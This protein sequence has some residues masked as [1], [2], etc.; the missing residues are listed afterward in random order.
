MVWLDF[1]GG[2]KSKPASTTPQ[3][4]PF[5][6]FVDP[7][8]GGSPTPANTAAWAPTQVGAA[9]QPYNPVTPPPENTW[10]S[11]YQMWQDP[12]NGALWDPASGLWIDPATMNVY[13][14][15]VGWQSIPEY[16]DYSNVLWEHELYTPY[17]VVAQPSLFQDTGPKQISGADWY[18]IDAAMSR[19]RLSQAQ[20]EHE[21]YTPYPSVGEN[22]NTLSGT[23]SGGYTRNE[24]ASLPDA[25]AAR[26]AQA[27]TNFRQDW[28]RQEQQGLTLGGLLGSGL[29]AYNKYIAN[30]IAETGAQLTPAVLELAKYAPGLQSVAAIPGMLG[31]DSRTATQ[32]GVGELGTALKQSG[33]NPLTFAELQ[34]ENFKERPGWQQMASLAVFDPTN[35][36]GAGLTTKALQGV[37]GEGLLSE[38][39]RGAGA[40]NQA[41]DTATAKVVGGALKPL[42]PALKPLAAE[43]GSLPASLAAKAGLGAAVGGATYLAS[44]S[45]D[46]PTQRLLKSL[47]VGL[48][49]A[50]APDA[51]RAGYGKIPKRGKTAAQLSASL[52]TL[53][54][55]PL[56]NSGNV[57]ALERKEA[58]TAQ[59]GKLGSALGKLPGVKGVAGVVNPSI[60]LERSVHVANQ[61]EAAVRADLGTRFTATRKPLLQQVQDAFGQFVK[62]SDGYFRPA[63][64]PEYIGPP[65]RVI[66]GTIVDMMENP[67]DYALTPIQKST[68]DLWELRDAQNVNLLRTQHAADIGILR[69]EGG[70]KYVPHINTNEDLV[71]QGLTTEQRL[72]NPAL[73]KERS[74]ETA[75]QRMAADP[76]FKPETDPMMLMEL[77]DN[78]LARLGGQQTFKEGVGGYTRTELIEQV[79]PDLVQ[80]K[81]AAQSRLASL[82]GKLERRLQKETDLAGAVRKT[83][84]KQ[85]IV[86]ERLAP[87]EARV[88][89]LAETGDYGP[90]LSHL[91]GQVYELR[92]QADALE[93]VVKG[94]KKRPGMAA[95]LVTNDA[96]IRSI[97]TQ[98]EAA[99]KQVE[100]LVDA[101]AN[102]NLTRHGF[103]RSDYT[104][105]YHSPEVAESISEI[106]KVS[107][108]SWDRVTNIFDVARGTALSAD[109]SPIQVQGVMQTFRD[110]ISTMKAW[111]LMILEGGSSLDDVARRE[112]ELVSRYVQ[113]RARALGQVSDEF[114]PTQSLIASI[115]HGVGRKFTHVENAMFNA[116]QR[117]DYETWKTTRNVLAKINPHLPDDVIDH[118]AANAISKTVPGM[119]NVERGVSQARGKIERGI[120]TSTSFLASPAVV[121]KDASSAVVKLAM[122]K[123]PRGR[124][125]VALAHLITMTATISTLS[126]A[127]A[128]ATANER[129]LS[130]E[131][132]LKR[133]FNPA[134]KEF[135]SLHLPGGKRIPLGGP[136]RSFIRAMAPLDA[137][138]GVRTPRLLD[139]ARARIAPLPGAAFDVAANRDFVGDKVR[140]GNDIQQL[141]DSAYYLVEQGVLPLSVGGL[142]ET[143]RKGGSLGDAITEALSQ[144]SGNPPQPP[145]P[146]DRLDMIARAWEGNEGR[147]FYD[148]PPLVRKA[149]EERHPDLY[150][151]AIEEG[152]EARKIAF[153]KEQKAIVEQKASDDL[154]K[155]NDIDAATWRERYHVRYEALRNQKEGVYAL[156][157][158]SAGKDPVLD[159][160]FKAIEDAARADGSIDWDRVE[161]Y[162][163]S[164]PD[165]ARVYIEENT[166]L[167]LRTDKTKEYRADMA[168]IQNAGYWEL[169][170]KLW[171][172]FSSIYELPDSLTA[173]QFWTDMRKGLIA[174]SEEILTKKFGDQWRTNTPNAAIELADV[175]L[176]KAKGEYDDIL[177]KMRKNWRE[178]HPAEAQILAKW[179]MG[180]TGK[181]EVAE[182]II[183]GNR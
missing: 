67:Q 172:R 13:R 123:R 38:I 5:A 105:R 96:E 163:A 14:E 15:N 166:G 168:K 49:V 65:D 82:R 107:N 156:A 110:P 61:A 115:G 120:F 174:R 4:D 154:L 47:A 136:F 111:A 25:E 94:T 10:N 53:D 55:L 72:R 140:D 87:L 169:E 73:T 160:Y 79:R 161:A 86:D 43:A 167:S 50:I 34:N 12:K 28:Q 141:I 97:Q 113:A 99:Q 183:E 83:L 17:P 91:A 122:A 134:R 145:T 159:G 84:S 77:H 21:L 89:L 48:G 179:Q 85:R 153:E 33:G 64:G 133:A 129:N 144:A 112:P 149:I 8:S 151:E 147:D 31:Y 78:Q 19:P 150:R 146:T 62:G 130:P 118:E 60:N 162:T 27:L 93:R 40:A 143:L 180:G 26:R 76:T 90:E 173:E 152:S 124:E 29:A 6:N 137:D 81:K 131:E 176:R 35:L 104:F 128:L 32:R 125:Q 2:Y 102:V 106:K 7:Y 58:V 181:E 148:S 71:Q 170:D 46:D 117:V 37:K 11:D 119:S 88:N 142:A 182:R 74:Y 59:A 103:V 51:V 158:T 135:M 109:G 41:I 70:G 54:P 95:G 98:I 23:Y 116:I 24:A 75:A 45:D 177:S 126:G 108:G 157:G 3:P 155:S 132:A 42:G 18:N 138:G 39:L 52:A 164:L 92:R 20:L 44:D 68:L 175:G 165:D 171:R 127:T 139:W 178:E 1:E 57:R 63:S 66:Q 30:P 9:P 22:I 36:I 56:G 80:A 16:N 100:E 69:P 121:L 101:Y 114:D